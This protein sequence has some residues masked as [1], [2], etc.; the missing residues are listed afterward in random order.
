[1]WIDNQVIESAKASSFCRVW[2]PSAFHLVL[3]RSNKAA[4]EGH[5]ERLK[6]ATF[7]L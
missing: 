5:L 6:K 7:E 1:M 2:V 4:C 3:G